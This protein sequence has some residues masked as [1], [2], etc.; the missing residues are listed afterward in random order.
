MAEIAAL[1]DEL[2]APWLPKAAF[3]PRK[4]AL[5]ALGTIDA[6]ID[7]GIDAFTSLFKEGGKQGSAS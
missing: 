3:S 7:A 1:S 2:V 5:K 4:S 6:G